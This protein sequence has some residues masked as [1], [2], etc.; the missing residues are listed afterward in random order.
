MPQLRQDLITGKWVIIATERARRPHSFSETK[1]ITPKKTKICPFCYGNEYM[2]PPEVLA[3]RDNGKPNSSGWKVRVV[4]NKFPALIHEGKPELIKN[5]IYSTMSG[6]GAHEVIIHSPH[7]DLLLPLMNEEQVELVLKAYLIRYKELS[8]DLNLRFIHIIVNH[9][10][11]AGA[12]LD[13]PHSQLFGLPI[14]PDFVM[15][16][17]DGSKKYYNKFKKCVY[18]EII[19][20]EIR[21]GGRV[22]EETDEFIAFEPFASKLPF[23]TWIIP[24]KHMEH[25]S[26]MSENELRDCSKVLRNTMKKIYD[27]IN[28]P[29]LNYWLHSAPLH[30]QYKNYHWH[31]EIIPKLT[32][33]GGFELGTGTI[34]N[35]ALPEECAKYLRKF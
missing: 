10:K 35:T 13:H 3:F 1:R 24:K 28:D 16:E 26:D 32:T 14:V 2:T 6:V 34:I 25:F 9:G 31:F 8:K 5:G 27:G 17:L 20:N 19:K 15:D 7:H 33:T 23:E 29:P 4:P 18:C 21:D 22:I 30:N 12:S 11:E